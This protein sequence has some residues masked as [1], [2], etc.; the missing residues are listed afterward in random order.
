MFNESTTLAV[1]NRLLNPVGV[2][3]ALLLALYIHDEPLDGYYIVLGIIVFFLSAQLFED[4]S[5]MQPCGRFRPL[6]G[7][8]SIV[9]AW[10]M[11]VAAVVFLG[12][13]TRLE[14][15]FNM[16]VMWVWVLIVPF[17][18]FMAHA[19]TR[20]YV[21]LTYEHGQTRRGVIIGA[22]ELGLRLFHRLQNNDCL[23]TRM[24]GFFDDRLPDRLSPDA[25]ALYLGH[26][27]ELDAYINQHRVDV[28]YIA[29]PISQK[30]R[31]TA[32][33]N[34]LKDTTASVYLVPDIFTYDLIQARI[35]QVGGV[36]VIAVLETPFISIHA[37]NKRVTDLVLASVILLL[38]SPL[39][40]IIAVAVKL[41]SA[42][43][44]IFKQRR[45]GLNGDEIVVYKFRSM[46]V[47]EDGGTIEQAK[48]TDPR[49]T[50]IGA[51]LRKSSLDELP[52]FVNVL[53][54]RMSI[55]GPRPHAVAHN[56]MYR[57]LIPGYML[58]HKVKPG[59]TGWAQ[60][61]GLRGETDSLEKMAARVQYDLNYMR[62]WSLSLDLMIIAKTIWL[63][64]KDAKAY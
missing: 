43:P 59:I 16:D 34:H 2:L 22:N 55:V 3:A 30:D 64:F 31:I 54:G 35:D 29:L 63:V 33:L 32:L 42:G 4:V 44:I 39:L 14:D 52:Q 50:P 17:L 25:Q 8:V 49:V 47:C 51:F 61:N 48:K 1:L 5:L 38:I 13:V 46:H 62:K 24:L 26:P 60:V 15:H 21:R 53:Q 28:I 23:M 37:F 20:V 58:R 11:T 41:S 10:S 7:F 19:L 18:L 6:N 9:I 40:L 36:P 57:K 12:Y 56:E 45:Y 27:R